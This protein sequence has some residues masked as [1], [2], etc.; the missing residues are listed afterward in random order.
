MADYS[1]RFDPDRLRQM[2]A[3]GKTAREITEA[4]KISRYTLMEQL[5]MLQDIDRKVYAVKG[6]VKS[7]EKEHGHKEG[8]IISKKLKEKI[9]FSPG[10]SFEVIVEDD[11]IILKKVKGD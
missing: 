8:I 1:I 5:V 11:Q 2:I 10:D 3:E 6:L 7:P 4:L 9:C